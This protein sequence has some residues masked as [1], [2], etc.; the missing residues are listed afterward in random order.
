MN[1]HTQTR[2]NYTVTII[3][4]KIIRSAEAHRTCIYTYA[5]PLNIKHMR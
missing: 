3:I 2:D 4:I 1:T 5:I